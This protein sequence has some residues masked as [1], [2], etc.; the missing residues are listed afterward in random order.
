MIINYCAYTSLI[1]GLMRNQSVAL[2]KLRIYLTISL[3][4]RNRPNTH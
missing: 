4:M 3:L 1:T 2:L